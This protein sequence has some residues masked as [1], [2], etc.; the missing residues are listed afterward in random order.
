MDNVDVICPLYNASNYI[1][2]LDGMLKAQLNIKL[3]ILY[4]L[5]ESEDNTLELLNMINANY[6]TIKKNEFS[7]S[8]TREKAIFNSKSDYLILL[9]QD[10]ELVGVDTIYKFVKYTKENNLAGSY[11]KQKSIIGLDRY[12]REI[13]YGNS[14]YVFDKSNLNNKK[15]NSVFFSDTFSCID[16]KKFKEINGYDNKDF[17]TNEDMYFAYKCLKNNLKIGYF[18]DEYV[19]HSH[20][21]TLKSTYERYKLIGEFL[22]ENKD[23]D[24]LVQNKVAYLKI[25]FLALKRLDFLSLFILPH[26]VFARVLGLRKGK[27]LARKEHKKNERKVS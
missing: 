23:I 20:K 5:T 13:S 9:T 25:V 2:K 18:K 17:V 11:I 7:H 3:N 12:F 19:I 14:N 15:T 1:L 16:V 6:I 10:I 24:K 4:I 27:K 21:L 8:L 22:Y 26:N